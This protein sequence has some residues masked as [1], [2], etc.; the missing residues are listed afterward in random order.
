MILLRDHNYT[1]SQSLDYKS[2][3]LMTLEQ[4]YVDL[5]IQHRTKELCNVDNNMTSDL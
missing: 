1:L 4:N 2:G 5:M 3:R